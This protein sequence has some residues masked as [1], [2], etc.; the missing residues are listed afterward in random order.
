MRAVPRIKL[1]LV[2]ATLRLA[3]GFYFFTGGLCTMVLLTGPF[4]FA[5]L[6]A[7]TATNGV[8]NG[9]VDTFIFDWLTPQWFFLIAAT[10]SFLIGL[11]LLLGLYTKYTCIAGIIA[12]MLQCFALPVTTVPNLYFAIDVYTLPASLVLAPQI[13]LIGFLC[14]Q[15]PEKML[16]PIYHHT[17]LQVLFQ[18]CIFLKYNMESQKVF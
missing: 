13:G 3:L 6:Q 7:F 18:D 2:T 4:H 10:V 1:G 5:T 12:L 17:L 9:F 14:Q 11:N 15:I 8:V 16:L